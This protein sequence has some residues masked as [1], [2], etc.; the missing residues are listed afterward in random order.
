M[1]NLL[2]STGYTKRPVPDIDGSANTTA[3]ADKLTAWLAT[4][5]GNV[6]RRIAG[7]SHRTVTRDTTV[8]ITDGLIL[9]DTTARVIDVTWPVPA[10]VTKDWVVTI[11]RLNVGANDVTIVG[12]VDG[13]VNPTLAAQYKSLTIWSDGTLLHKVASV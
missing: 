1:A 7:A 3:W 13:V 9:C 8:L 10:S 5:F 6:Q 4:E 12:T 2:G 11:K